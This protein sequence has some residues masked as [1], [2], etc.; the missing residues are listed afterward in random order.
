MS[1]PSH[2][3][4]DYQ[5]IVD[6]T[7]DNSLLSKYPIIDTNNLAPIDVIKTEKYDNTPAKH[8]LSDLSIKNQD[9]PKLVAATKELYTLE[10]NSGKMLV[11]TGD[12]ANLPVKQAKEKV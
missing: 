1:V 4:Y 2:A 7:R 11:I 3:P 12:Y 5:A 10:F 9:D 8:L 6:F